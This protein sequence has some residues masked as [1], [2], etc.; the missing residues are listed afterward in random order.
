MT[1]NFSFDREFEDLNKLMRRLLNLNAIKKAMLEGTLKG[2][3][4]MQEIDE[5]G[6]KGYVIQGRF[7]QNQNT[8]SQNPFNPI[9]RRL[10]PPTPTRPEFS[11]ENVRDLN[12][13]LVDVLDEENEVKVYIELPLENKNEVK[14]NVVEGSVEVKTKNFY[15]LIKVPTNLDLE[16]ASSRHKNSVLEVKIPKKK[17]PSESDKHTI[18]IEYYETT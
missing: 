16:K 4:N 2:S 9:N 3:W 5:P 10:K 1:S 18:T 11:D 17:E 8:S 15:K 6:V 7:K 12:E 13:P 14:L